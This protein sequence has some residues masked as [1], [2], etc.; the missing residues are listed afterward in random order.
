M[1]KKFEGDEKSFAEKSGLG[2]K[3][4]EYAIHGGRVPV[5]VVGFD[6][7]VAVVVISGLKKEQGHMVAIEG[8]VACIQKMRKDIAE[9]TKQIT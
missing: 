8:F 9:A 6:G 5:R 4:G 7:L 2:P 1:H 3:T